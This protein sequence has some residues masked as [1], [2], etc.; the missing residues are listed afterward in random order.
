MCHHTVRFGLQA[1]T[2]TRRVSV[3]G[4]S[5]LDRLAGFVPCTPA[6]S[7]RLHRR[8]KANTL[9]ATGMPHP[10]RLRSALPRGTPRGRRRVRVTCVVRGCVLNTARPVSRENLEKDAMRFV[11]ARSGGVK[12]LT[13]A[14][15]SSAS[16]CACCWTP[17]RT[18]PRPDRPAG[19]IRSRASTSCPSSI[20]APRVS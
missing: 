12:N 11:S 2:Q 19:P 20:R 7:A 8:R 18:A 6:V 10:R 9:L 17:A 3:G 16:I 13:R 5:A 4:T 1:G 14:A 15:T